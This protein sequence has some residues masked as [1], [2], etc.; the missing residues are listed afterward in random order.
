MDKL[1]DMN[2]AS[3]DYIPKLAATLSNTPVGMLR[4]C[5]RFLMYFSYVLLGF[6]LPSAPYEVVVY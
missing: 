2:P 5:I 1:L 6:R 4:R 3:L